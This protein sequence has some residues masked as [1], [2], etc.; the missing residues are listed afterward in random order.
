M[1]RRVT[2][3]SPKI[4]IHI[5]IFEIG[6]CDRCTFVGR[7]LPDGAIVEEAIEG[8]EVGSK[9]YKVVGSPISVLNVTNC[10]QKGIIIQATIDIRR[11]KWRIVGLPR[12][13]AFRTNKPSRSSN[14]LFTMISAKR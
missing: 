2:T 5:R 3:R 8:P 9:E 14:E 7:L 1:Y 4:Q 10:E 6:L 11:T 12:P 13:I